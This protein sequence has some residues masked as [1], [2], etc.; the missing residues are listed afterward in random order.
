[1]KKRTD[2]NKKSYFGGT[3]SLGKIKRKIFNA[4]I[5][6]IMLFSVLLAAVG[7]VISVTEKRTEIDRNLKNI[8][9]T[10]VYSPM[11]SAIDIND[12]DAVSAPLF[13][14]Y[15]DALKTSLSQVDVISI[16][17]REGKRFYHTTSSLTGTRYDGETPSFSDKNFYIVDAV[18]PSGEQRRAYSAVYSEDGTYQGF[19]MVII[20][21]QNLR[22]GITNIVVIYAAI[23][24][25]I[26]ALELLL[27][28][29]LG[30]GIKKSLLG[31]EPD[32]ITAMY[33][34]RDNIL[35][36][37]D[38]GVAAV[39][40]KGNVL[41]ANTSAQKMICDGE[42]IVGKNLDCFEGCK[43]LKTALSGD[44][45]EVNVRIDIC[46]REAL[47]DRIPVQSDDYVGTIAIIKDRA[48]Y[49]ELMEELAGTRYLVDSMR[50]NNHDFTNKLHVI[51]G[52]IQ[53]GMYDKATD[54][55]QN[56]TLVQRETVSKIMNAVNEPS[57]AALLIGK[58]AR[59]AELNVKFTL[60]EGSLFNKSDL[61]IPTETFITILGNL[62]ENAFDSL[63]GRSDV[64]DKQIFVGL[65]T[66]RNAVL[67]T[68]EDNGGGMTEET[69]NR[70][71]ENG[72][73]TKGANR[74]TGMYRVKSLVDE[75][76][77][78]TEIESTLGVGASIAI[79]FYR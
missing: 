79:S 15:L 21:S 66:K 60:K 20:L 40:K 22:H 2:D 61:W 76:N 31:Y 49:T 45:R 7:I 25:V 3:G 32:A 33:L 1:M 69:V 44:G 14:S 75:F 26:V 12:A 78:K 65:Y 30:S 16:V 54:Y 38:E 59:A 47:I 71:F 41:F 28:Q 9:D 19:I 23:T 11:L 70:I 53:M 17:N 57:M 34:V 74:G 8:S 24:A 46:G 67:I 73:S 55:I 13:C 4:Q 72:F 68:V 18:G 37:V 35:E 62:I 5:L 51:M 77:G 27:A 58:V 29:W 56:I 6:L 48:K 36:S 63:N 43:E 10:I 39:D 42:N 50:A 64:Q 52:L